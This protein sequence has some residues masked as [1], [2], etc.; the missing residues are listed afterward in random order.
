MGGLG[1]LY[2]DTAFSSFGGLAAAF[3]RSVAPAALAEWLPR[4][5]AL[6]ACAW[7]ERDTEGHE[8][9]LTRFYLTF[10]FRFKTDDNDDYNDDGGAGV[11]ACAVTDW[12]ILFWMYGLVHTVS[13]TVRWTIFEPAFRLHFRGAPAYRLE[14][15]KAMALF[16][17]NCTATLF[18]LL[19]A[20]FAFR[21]LATK[22]WLYNEGEWF[23]RSAV[24]ALDLKFFY[25]LYAAR[26]M[27]DT[28]SIMHE[29]RRSDTTA[30][31]IH[32]IATVLLVLASAFTG[33]TKAGGV[34]M[35][36][37]D[38]AD[39]PMLVAKTF[40]YLSSDRADLYQF[41]SDRLFEVFAIVFIATRN[42]MFP[43]FVY[44]AV[45]SVDDG[46][47]HATLRL[48]MKVLLVTLVLL[49]FYWF[50]LILQAAAYRRYENKGNID[51]IREEGVQLIRQR[52]VIHGKEK[53]S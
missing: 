51:D 27:S 11:E 39:L 16:S 2:L 12:A 21:V 53:K 13:W 43:Y 44:V 20:Y 1:I 6:P 46:D 29:H 15:P 48:A 4:R 42:I 52:A 32:H 7:V 37:M 9:S 34:L 25:L 50:G 23:Q 10:F 17:Q 26:Y 40:K 14:D 35:F 22:S 31:V 30:Y 24:I 45:N 33:Y 36:F 41:L 47:G 38:W 18:H 19:S 28:V 49:M 5:D 3:A 8:E